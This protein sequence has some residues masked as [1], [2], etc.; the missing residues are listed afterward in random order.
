MLVTNNREY[1]ERSVA[2]AHYMR[3]GNLPEDSKY[4]RYRYTCT[5]FKYR[6]HPFAAAIG[7]VQLR[8]L[9]TLRAEGALVKDE[10]YPLQHQQPVYKE[11]NIPVTNLPVTEK[12]R[13]KIIALPTF[14]NAE[15]E[16]LDQYFESFKKVIKN[17]EKLK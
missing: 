10:R 7:R 16:L 13:D 4:K 3:I 8:Y 5:G 2:L 14:P 9:D 6:I 1:F 17:K 11:K 15:E 12:I